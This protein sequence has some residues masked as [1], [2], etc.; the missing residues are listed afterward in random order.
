MDINYI[1]ENEEL[2]KLLYTSIEK[3]YYKYKMTF[4][5]EKEDFIQE[6]FL[7]IIPRIKNFDNT[8]SSLKTYIPLL[9]MSC[10]K[11]RVIQSANGQSKN[12]NKLKFNNN[13]MSLDTEIDN[14]ENNAKIENII[15]DDHFNLEIK[16]VLNEILEMS[17][18]T[19]KQ[20][21]ILILMS[22]GYTTSDI[23]RML[24]KSACC[25]NIT[26][27]RAKEKINKKYNLMV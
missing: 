18:L 14:T 8:K 10:A 27:Q 11:N 5:I 1:L 26:F 25:V 21:Q 16:L 22:K 12:Y 2:N 9:I 13:T 19:E 23:A 7:F 3:T 17:N 24:N 6:V 20:R 4:I 15:A